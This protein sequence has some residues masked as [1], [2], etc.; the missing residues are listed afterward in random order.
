MRWLDSITDSTGP[1]FEQNLGDSEGQRSL[2]CC[3]SRG[4]KKLDTTQ[5]LNNNCLSQFESWFVLL[6]SKRNSNWKRKNNIVTVCRLYDTVYT[7]KILRM[8]PENYQS[9]SMN[10]VK[11]QD[12][13]LTHRNPF[14]FY[15]LT[16]KYQKEKLKKQSHLPSHQKNNVKYLGINL[17]QETKDLYSENNKMLMKEIEDNTSRWKD[18]PCSWIGIISID[19][20]TLQLKAIYRFMQSLSNYLWHFPRNQNKKS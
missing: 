17:P 10:V 9:S 13:K 18:T 16:T 4:C 1:E 19:K 6:A 20:M 3:S 7:Q 5:Q 8:L 15:T 14:H 12:T 11:F 2:A